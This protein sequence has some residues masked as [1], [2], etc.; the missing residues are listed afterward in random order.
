MAWTYGKLLLLNGKIGIV[1][2]RFKRVF[3]QIEIFGG[4]AFLCRS[5]EAEGKKK[6]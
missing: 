4:G 1:D 2:D 6:R 5:C 3:W